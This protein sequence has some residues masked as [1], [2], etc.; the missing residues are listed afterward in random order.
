MTVPLIE[1][2]K[3]SPALDIIEQAN[4]VYESPLTRE[5]VQ[6]L[7]AALG[8]PMKATLMAAIQKGNLVTFPGMTTKNVARFFPEAEETQ[9]GHIRQIC[10]GK[11]LT[12]PRDI[13]ERGAEVST[14]KPGDKKRDL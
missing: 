13:D 5:V 1:R 14:I 4:N 8:F 7:H 6:C 12:R 10:Q 2:E 3:I 11:H 9:K